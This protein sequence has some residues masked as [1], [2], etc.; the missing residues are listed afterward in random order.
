MPW[1]VRWVA[2]ERLRALFRVAPG[3]PASLYWLVTPGS[4][5]SGTWRG[6]HGMQEVWG[7]NPHSSTQVTYLIRTPNR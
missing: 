7:S 4:R 2:D 3:C 1:V 5:R 6:L